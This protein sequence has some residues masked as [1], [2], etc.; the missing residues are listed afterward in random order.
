LRVVVS[1]STGGETHYEIARIITPYDI[2]GSGFPGHCEWVLD[3]SDYESLLRD[4]V[5]LRN[6]IESWIGGERGWI[7]TIRFAFIP[8]ITSLEPY[9]VIN[10]YQ[11]DH[12]VYGDPDNPHEAWLPSRPVSIPSEIVRAKVRSVTTGHGQ[13]NTDNAAEFAYKW[14]EIWVGGDN[15]SHFLWRTDCAQNECSPQGGTWRYPRAGWCPG[16]KVDPWDVDISAS[17]T[18]GCET[19]IDYNIQ[20]YENFCRPNNPNCIEPTT[21]PDCDYNY[22]GHTEPHFTL[23]S[24]LILYRERSPAEL[25]GEHDRTDISSSS[26]PNPAV[27]RAILEYEVP[28][29][30]CVELTILS[31][32][33]RVVRRVVRQPAERGVSS[34]DWDGTDD[35]GQSC[36]PGTYF[37]E[38]RAGEWRAVRKVIYLRS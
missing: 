35:R 1:D 12:I 21:C 26:R 6:Y 18:P 24:Q 36:P 14:H 10:L 29:P 19:Q 15:F 31:A 23:Q 28:A 13:G 30:G 17:V 11:N 22:Q 3:V 20:P 33:G 8:G 4:R 38:V 7:V 9:R 34:Y 5:T 27:A 25:L 37:F 32:D 2:T 16:D